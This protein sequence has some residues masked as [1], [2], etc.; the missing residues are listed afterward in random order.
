[1]T[2]LEATIEA[3]MQL[4]T[5]LGAAGQFLSAGIVRALVGHLHAKVDAPAEPTDEDVARLVAKGKEL[6]AL[7][8]AGAPPK[9]PRGRPRK[10]GGG[11]GAGAVASEPS[12]PSPASPATPPAS[13]PTSHGDVPASVADVQPTPAA[14]PA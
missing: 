14:V 11:N 1:M 4:E 2:D 3:G 12:S 8:Q 7:A 13:A 6:T 5:D 9:A 10:S